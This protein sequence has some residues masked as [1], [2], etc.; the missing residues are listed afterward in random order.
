MARHGKVDEAAELLL[1]GGAATVGRRLKL[2][3]LGRAA[4]LLAEYGRY[5]KALELYDKL[6]ARTPSLERSSL[7]TLTR[8]MTWLAYRAGKYERAIKGFQ[9]LIDK[10][11]R[12]RR[13]HQLPKLL[14]WQARAHARA[15]HARQA[16]ALYQQIVEKHLRN[17][18]GLQ[19]RSRLMEA[20]KVKLPSVPCSP[21]APTVPGPNDAKMLSMLDKLIIRHG[22]LYPSLHR[23]R[24]LWR[25]GMIEDARRE[26]RLIAIDYAWVRARGRPKRVIVRPPAWRFWRD[27]VVPTRRRRFGRRERK[28]FKER[29]GINVALGEILARA[30]IFYFAQRFLPR[31]GDLV[32]RRY[33]RGYA[34][35]VIAAAKRFDLDPNLLWAVIKT[36]STFRTDAISRASATGLMQI[37]PNTARRIAAEMRLEGFERTQLFDPRTNVN[38][39]AWY[40]K[41]LSKK[42]KGQLML[43]AAAY[44]G[45][46]HNVALWIDKRGRGADLDEFIEEIPF[47]ESRRYAKKILR[48][49]AL[50]ERVYC[51]KDDRTSSNTL[52]IR[53][54]AHPAY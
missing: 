10:A 25:L 50:Y 14:Y 28:I 21:V 41:A 35:E 33:P 19:A 3:N 15:G 39:A 5:G 53:Y 34:V 12:R 22:D 48:L 29:K 51:G 13:S 37:M 43:V 45:G 54:G 20:G 4:F 38:M 17:Y 1:H 6:I 40:L 30:G 8:R 36:E 47:D 11:R 27:S 42:L 52:D 26:L 31:T 16:E 49:V 44:N 18:Y 32:R 9:T 23:V 7:S 46:P 24:T 2:A